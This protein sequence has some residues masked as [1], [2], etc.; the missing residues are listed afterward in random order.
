MSANRFVV[1]AR[2]VWEFVRP[3]GE[4]WG[5]MSGALSIPVMLLALFNVG[6]QRLL[7]AVLAYASL[8]A[9]VIVQNWQISKLKSRTKKLD[10]TSYDSFDDLF[11][12]GDAMMEKFLNNE[13]PL[14]TK[15]EFQQWD[16]RLIALAESCATIEERNKLRAGS[17]LDVSSHD[18][19]AI[20]MT[21]DTPPFA[22]SLVAKLQISRE[23][24]ERLRR[25]SGNH[26]ASHV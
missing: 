18:I 15:K 14:P 6:S 2:R 3:I 20:Y 7:F 5:I 22:E 10:I 16:K 9:V 19:L 23:I 13:T 8:L 12:Q 17:L 1:I 21:A 25:E 24:M 11:Q 4:W 26:S